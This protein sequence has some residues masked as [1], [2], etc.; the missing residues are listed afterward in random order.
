MVL[1]IGELR[2]RC[3]EKFWTILK[4]VQMRMCSRK[5]A[6]PQ[7]KANDFVLKPRL[8]DFFVVLCAFARDM[9]LAFEFFMLRIR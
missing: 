7:R 8:K 9:L 1:N 4:K 6:K 5:A 2:I 3:Q